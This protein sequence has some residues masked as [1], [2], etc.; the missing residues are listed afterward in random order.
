MPYLLL[1]ISNQTKNKNVQKI[2]PDVSKISK[3][4]YC[5]TI[6]IILEWLPAFSL[7]IYKPEA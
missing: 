3:A 6:F 5:S 2:Y 1:F 4:Y 7:T